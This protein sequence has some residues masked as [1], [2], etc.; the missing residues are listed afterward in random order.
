MMATT[1]ISSAFIRDCR[2][3]NIAGY[4]PLHLFTFF[5]A[6]ALPFGIIRIRRGDV[7]GHKSVMKKMFI[8]ACCVAGAFTLLPGRLL[9]DLLWKHALGLLA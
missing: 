7:S 9:G 1:A 5:V 3:P 8:G 4:T 2:L 6:I